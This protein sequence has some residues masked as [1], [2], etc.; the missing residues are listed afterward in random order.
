MT[1]ENYCYAAVQRHT[2]SREWKGFRIAPELWEL[3]ETKLRDEQWSPEEISKTFASKGVGKVSHETI[4]QHIYQDKKVGGDL[5][6]HLRH[7]CKS[8]RQRGS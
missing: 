1:R 8:Y 4:Y 5:H 6:R 2:E 3:V 7:R